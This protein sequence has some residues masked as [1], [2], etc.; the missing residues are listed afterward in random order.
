MSEH[1]D[2][3]EV[4]EMT[5]YQSPLESSEEPI[6]VTAE[7]IDQA[8]A[9]QV[10][11]T[12]AVFRDNL[13]ALEAYVDRQIA[14]YA[15]T[16][17][18][19]CDYEQVK[20][21]RNCMADLN[22]LKDPIEKERK[23][24]KREYEAPLKAFES[25]VKSITS[26]IDEVRASIKKQVDEADERFRE[27]RRSMML[28]EYEGMAG[29]ISDIIPFSAILEDTWLNRSTAE[30]K[31]INELCE[32]SAKA[33]KGYEALQT[34]QLNHK[35]EV[36]KHYAE[37][38]DL[39]AALELE[40]KLNDDDKK[41]AEFKAKQEAAEAVKAQRTTPEPKQTPTP[42]AVQAAEPQQDEPQVLRYALSME[43]TGTQAYAQHVANTLKGLGLTGAT[44]KCLG[45]VGN[46]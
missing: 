40:D 29:I 19:P 32:K 4:E 35:D 43:F 11:Y 1:T 46:E 21:A 31:A 9:L 2:M 23:R 22:K 14:I 26:R 3:V 25:R 24:I 39:I 5:T 6:E 41:M 15:G 42:A 37:T 10:V 13:A 18:D 28:E 16:E 38:L 20:M 33:V 45:V 34:K 8:D 30:S 17:I 27:L 7:V 44:L 36:V 12:P